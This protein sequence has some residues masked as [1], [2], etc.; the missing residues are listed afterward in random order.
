MATIFLSYRRTDSPQACRVYDWLVARFGQDAVFM[1]VAAIPVAVNY[2]DFL[3]QQIGNCKLVLALIGPDWT[4]KIHQPDDPVRME[5]ESAIGHQVT[6]LPVLIGDTPMPPAEELPKSITTVATQNAVVVGVSRDFYTHM[7]AIL[8]KVEA[9]LGAKA[10]QSVVLGDAEVIRHVCEGIV[11]FL[12]RRYYEDK[13]NVPLAYDPRLGWKV[14]GTTYF[15]MPDEQVATLFLHRML[16]LADVLELH[17][18]ISFWSRDVNTEHMLSG[19]VMQQLERN[20]VI[21]DEAFSQIIGTSPEWKV[22]VRP[23]DEDPRQIWKSITNDRLRLSVAYVA[24]VSPKEPGDP[25]TSPKPL[26]ELFPPA[27]R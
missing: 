11:W 10:T 1:D 14:I 24:T 20:P 18:L 5:L 21:P 25:R 19:W 9:I 17:I 23:S 27:P 7:Q 13:D 6:V 12:R 26:D 2:P 16:R 3:S 22:K 8:P 15:E 4:K